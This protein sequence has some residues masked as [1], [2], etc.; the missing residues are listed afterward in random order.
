MTDTTKSLA[1]IIPSRLQRALRGSAPHELYV[2]RAIDSV[3]AQPDVK[4][5]RVTVSFLVGVDPGATLP[6][7]L[8]GHPNV[9]LHVSQHPSQAG[10]LNACIAALPSAIDIVAFLEDDDRWEE[11]YLRWALA[12]L[13]QYDFVSS[14]QLEVDEE[15]NIVRIND[16]PTPS[17]WIMHRR[18]LATV[19]PFSTATRWHLDN[20]WLGRLAETGLRRCHMTEMTAPAALDAA[21]QVRPW[22]ANVLRFGGPSVHLRRHAGLAP[23]VIR[24]VHPRSGMAQIQTNAAAFNQS[25][26]EQEGLMN[27]FGRIPW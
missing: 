17:G 18:T 25:R 16:F 12:A 26:S 19:G 21:H 6:Q 1:V 22:L 4:S 23:L 8:A 7:E 3:E 5:G 24:M 27:R 14:T 9:S 15:N 11:N 13:A 10:A 20:E 2:K